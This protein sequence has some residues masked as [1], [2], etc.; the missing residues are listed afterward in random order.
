MIELTTGIAFLV[1]SIYVG[2]T[3][4]ASISASIASAT[5]AN[6]A[7]VEQ[8]ATSAT[9]TDEARFMNSKVLEAYIK[10]QDADEPIL[11]D[12]ARCEST[13]RQFDQTGNILRGVVNPGDVGVMQINE[14]YHADEAAKLGYNIY[15]V[16]GNVAFGRYLYE[17]YG[18]DPWSSSSPCWGEGNQL[19]LK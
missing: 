2:P 10:Q 11:V 9:T 8:G 1:T 3:Q 7:T 6:Q 19:A 13:F 5:Q 4:D 16:E 12:I 18:T 15:T 14:S 17:K